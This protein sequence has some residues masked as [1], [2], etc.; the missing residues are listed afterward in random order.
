MALRESDMEM[1]LTHSSRLKSIPWTALRGIAILVVLV[2]LDWA[3]VQ[4]GDCFCANGG[5]FHLLFLAA[6]QTVQA[7]ILHQHGFLGWL[8]QTL[9]SFGPLLS[10]VVAAI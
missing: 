1:Q 10:L 9:L 3:V 6:C 5:I 8:L 2:S 7:F 4:S